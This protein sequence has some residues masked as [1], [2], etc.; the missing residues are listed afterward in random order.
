MYGRHIIMVVVV[1]LFLELEA[2]LEYCPMRRKKERADEMEA[3]I[4]GARASG[5]GG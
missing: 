4:G 5:G 1:A 2:P 3:S